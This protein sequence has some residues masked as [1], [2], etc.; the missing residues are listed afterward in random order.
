MRLCRNGYVYDDVIV[1][2]HSQNTLGE[3]NGIVRLLRVYF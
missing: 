1:N 3:S 2:L